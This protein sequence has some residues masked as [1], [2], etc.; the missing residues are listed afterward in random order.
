MPTASSAAII[1]AR[2]DAHLKDRARALGASIGMTATEID[3]AWDRL[4]TLPVDE[5]G[6]SSIATVYEYAAAQYALAVAALPPE[7]GVNPAGVTD[8]HILYALTPHTSDSGVSP[9]D[10]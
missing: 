10:G 3:A 8:A 2:D 5:S 9:L 6:T 4:V 1:A 7:P